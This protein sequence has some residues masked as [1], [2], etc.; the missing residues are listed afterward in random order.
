MFNPGGNETY[1]LEGVKFTKESYLNNLDSYGNATDF[2]IQDE[3]GNDKYT[4]T[5]N[6]YLIIND[7]NG[8]DKYSILG[9]SK[10]CMIIDNNGND[11][12]NYNGYNKILL[13]NLIT[14]FTKQS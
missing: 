3:Y 10:C 13:K 7:K 6:D 12:Y 2:V 9:N 11:T 1:K 14:C 8:K 5:D 4:L